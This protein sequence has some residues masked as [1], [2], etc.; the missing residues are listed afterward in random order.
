MNNRY[1]GWGETLIMA[2]AVIWIIAGASLPAPTVLFGVVEKIGW[3][4]AI[5]GSAILTILW[6][7]VPFLLFKW[8]DRIRRNRLISSLDEMWRD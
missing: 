6:L 8:A 2:I 7:G 1:E 4:N 3:S 5:V